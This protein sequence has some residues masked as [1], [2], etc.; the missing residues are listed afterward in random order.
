MNTH[1]DEMSVEPVF[2]VGTG[3]CGSTL[4]SNLLRSHPAVLSLSELFTASVP[5]TFLP[6][7][8]TGEQF[9]SILAEPSALNAFLVREDILPGEVL[10][11]MGPASGARF[12]GQPI[13]P[14][15]AITLPHLVADP[16][17]LYAELEQVV[18]GFPQAL[19]GDHYRRLFAWLS[20]RLDRPLVVERSAGSLEYLAQVW[21]SFP[22]ARFVHVVRR[23]PDCALSMRA[24]PTY[25]M[26]R[27]SG[28]LEKA[29][30]F[31]PY[32]E[33]RP[34]DP[35]DVPDNLRPLLPATF[36]KQAFLSLPISA[37]DFGWV[38][39]ALIV[40]GLRVLKQLPAAQLHILHYEDLLENP[41]P[42]LDELRGFLE[43]PDEG[44]QWL[45]N[46][47][48]MVDP[49]RPRTAALEPQEAKRLA[50]A[51]S[52]ATRYLRR[53]EEERSRP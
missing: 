6:G 33:D 15:L 46:A 16:D 51:T 25:R 19:V 4:L 26:M 23:G 28:L 12:A 43:L 45:A 1:V 41:G 22:K 9:W 48:A 29:L 11:P 40:A 18:P 21:D 37:E 35:L 10:Y 20:W 3:R 36:D 32:S 8:L 5:N 24:H 39:S 31:D 27:I 52:T 50:R 17:S 42:T 38:W 14:V 7:D 53:F 47:A 13:P 34:Y 2:V 30:G 49:K 44:G